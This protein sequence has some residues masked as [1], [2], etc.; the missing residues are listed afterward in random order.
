M[1]DGSSF[2]IIIDQIGSNDGTMTNMSANDIVIN[3]P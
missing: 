2:P 3:T 1:G